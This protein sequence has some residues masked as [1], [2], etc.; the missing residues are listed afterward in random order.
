MV[1]AHRG[2]ADGRLDLE[3]DRQGGQIHRHRWTGHA[4]VLREKEAG[5]VAVPETA[6]LR[7][8]RLLTCGTKLGDWR[9]RESLLLILLSLG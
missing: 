4:R 7:Y 1:P 5:W 9:Y 3:Q 8:R 2:R 6:Y